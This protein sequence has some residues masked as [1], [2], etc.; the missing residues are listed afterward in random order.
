VIPWSVV[1]TARIPGDGGEMRLHQRGSE[2]SIRV[3]GYE[4]MNSR[5]HASE[6]ALASLTCERI[7]G[8]PNVRVLIG[9]LGMGCT[10]LGVLEGLA[11][12]SDVVVAELVP[13]V[14]AWHRGPL[15]V[16]SANALDDP[17]VTV[18]EVDVA[19]VIAAE[20]SAYD[21]ILLDVDNG[22]S[23]LTAKHNDWLYGATGLRAAFAALKAGGILAVWSAGPDPAFTRR[24]QQAGFESEEVRVRGRARGKGSRFLIWLAQR[25]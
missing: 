22:P 19:R 8:R 10:L 23:A 17:R 2:Y 3:G 18:R 6:D 13:E 16:V 5:V 12:N 15:S 11:P 20:R 7:A 1:G 14:V 9:G 4:L 24:L 25:K 21:A